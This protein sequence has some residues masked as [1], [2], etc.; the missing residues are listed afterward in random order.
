LDSRQAVPELQQKYCLDG[1]LD[2]F[3]D[4]IGDGFHQHLDGVIKKFLLTTIDEL[5]DHE[6]IDLAYR[7]VARYIFCTNHSSNI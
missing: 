6:A 7:K 2:D 5:I 4:K 3:I 1:S